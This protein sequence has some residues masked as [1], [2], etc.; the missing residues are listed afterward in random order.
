LNGLSVA[1]DAAFI[2]VRGRA[3]W[4]HSK[5]LHFACSLKDVALRDVGPWDGNGNTT[6]NSFSP[7][8]K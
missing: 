1:I 5:S 6:W 3:G 2:S 8:K 7:P 4:K